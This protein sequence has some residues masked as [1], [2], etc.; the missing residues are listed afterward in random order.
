MMEYNNFQLK[1]EQELEIQK[2]IYKVHSMTE[3][4]KLQYIQELL[5]KFYINRNYYNNVIK[6]KFGL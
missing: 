3:R 1:P 4:E 2:E 6:L 5:H